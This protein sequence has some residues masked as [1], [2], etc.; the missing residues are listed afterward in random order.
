M[1]CISVL[2]GFHF[3]YRVGEISI[4]NGNDEHTILNKD[5]LFENDKGEFINAVDARHHLLSTICVCIVILCSR[6]A[7]QTGGGILTLSVDILL[8]LFN[9][10]KICSTGHKIAPL[11][12]IKSSSFDLSE[13]LVTNYV[14]MKYLL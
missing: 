2:L 8:L 1:I 12:R 11:I 13:S 5:V 9:C 10:W 3:G 4:S 14:T 7:N 6:K